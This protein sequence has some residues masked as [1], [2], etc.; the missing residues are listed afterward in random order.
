MHIPYTIGKDE[1]K[2][3]ANKEQWFK[4][5]KDKISIE[6]TDAK[7][8]EGVDFVYLSNIP[9]YAQPEGVEEF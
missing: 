5:N 9:D 6:L 8:F 3:A 2:R 4:T 1:C 7:Y